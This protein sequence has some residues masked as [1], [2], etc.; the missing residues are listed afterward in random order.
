MN[1]PPLLPAERAGVAER[2]GERTDVAER[3]GERTDV[4]E[5][6]GERTDVAERAGERTDVEAPAR[7]PWLGHAVEPVA[8]AARAVGARSSQEAWWGP[9]L[10][11]AAVG[12]LVAS[13][14]A[15]G[16]VLAVEAEPEP[17]AAPAV[18]GSGL[19]LRGDALD[20]QG[21]LRAVQDGVVSTRP[22][23]SG[24]VP[25]APPGAVRRGRA[26]SSTTAG[27]SSPTAVPR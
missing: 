8:E 1:G 18:A 22:P 16:V 4:A 14:V 17:V 20:V 15:A 10:L 24:P 6:A 9:A 19:S 23:S 11:G 3:A 27:S 21:V 26:W 12:A 7:P 5:R 13:V 25:S 2:A